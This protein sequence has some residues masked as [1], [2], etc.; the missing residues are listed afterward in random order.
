VIIPGAWSMEAAPP[1]SRGQGRF[2]DRAMTLLELQQRPSALGQLAGLQLTGQVAHV[3]PQVIGQVFGHVAP[4]VAQVGAQVTH[5]SW[6]MVTL[7]MPRT[8]PRPR[9]GSVVENDSTTSSSG[10]RLSLRMGHLAGGEGK[11]RLC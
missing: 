6:S 3:F 11:G 1:S 10:C 7:S 4:Q 8:V 9:A 2:V 5:E